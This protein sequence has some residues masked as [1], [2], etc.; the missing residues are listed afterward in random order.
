MA[1][2]RCHTGSLKEE[3]RR[4]QC[5]N[6]AGIFF[7]KEICPFLWGVFEKKMLQKCREQWCG[8]DLAEVW[9]MWVS[10]WAPQCRASESDASIGA[11]FAADAQ[12]SSLDQ[13]QSVLSL[14][15]ATFQSCVKKASPA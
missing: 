11:T 8:A 7:L 14:T 4:L 6:F 9:L 3:A 2:L 13:L 12:L 15:A 1:T 5:Y 10:A